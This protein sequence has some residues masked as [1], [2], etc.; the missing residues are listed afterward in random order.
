MSGQLHDT[1]PAPG[2]A[3]RADYGTVRLGQRDIDGLILCAEHYA[4]RYDLLT[5]ALGAQPA[6]LRGITARWRRAGY[7]ATGRLGPGP[8]WCWLTPA[9]IREALLT[10]F[11]IQALYRS[12]MHQVT[13]W[14][15]LTSDTPRTI[16]APLTDPRTDSDT[17]TPTPGQDPG[18][19]SAP[20]PISGA[21]IRD[22]RFFRN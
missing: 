15:T 11:D 17:S 3:R 12:D 9:R 6:R 19:H 13:I 5:A 14:A 21:A 16:T 8:A 18:Y 22:D 7:A 2:T 4:A 20:A 1:V 10:A